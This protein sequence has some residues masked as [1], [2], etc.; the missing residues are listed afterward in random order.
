[1]TEALTGAIMEIAISIVGLVAA[2]VVGYIGR[3]AKRTLD[4]KQVRRYSEALRNFD[5]DLYA[6]LADLGAAVE[7]KIRDSATD[8][9]ESDRYRMLEGATLEHANQFGRKTGVNV[10]FTAEDLE[11]LVRAAMREGRVAWER[12]YGASGAKAAP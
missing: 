9:H 6:S 10:E 3:T 11:A 4:S 5:E 12:A 8:Y 2:V 1:M 7:E